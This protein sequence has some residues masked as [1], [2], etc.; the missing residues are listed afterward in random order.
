[1]SPVLAFGA[2][3]GLGWAAAWWL[4]RRRENMRARYLSFVAH[5]LNTPV[6]ALNMTVLNFVNGLFGPVSDE[7]KPWL[8]LMRE[9]TARLSA[10]VGDLRDL[11]HEEFHRDLHLS[12]ESVPL[13]PLLE[14][15]LDG[16]RDSFSRSGA[17]LR[18]SG[19]DALPPAHGDADR[20]LRVFSAVLTHAR[21]FRSKGEVSVAGFSAEGGSRVGLRVDYEGPTVPP[22]LVFKAL[23][24]FYPVHN[25]KSQVLASTGLG[26][27]LANRL[28]EA[29]GGRMSLSVDPEG[30]SRIEVELP[31]SRAAAGA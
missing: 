17:P 23:D 26:L 8:V 24:L 18:L 20:L 14:Q 28:V 30:R 1:M 5:E 10:L 15:C 7:H 22:E 6:S 25:P 29:H 2:G 27:G 13:A 21:K 16:M 3:L 11:L 12:L 19:L 4:F 31:V 9:Q